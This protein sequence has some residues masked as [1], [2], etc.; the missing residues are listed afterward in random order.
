MCP[1]SKHSKEHPGAILPEAKRIITATNYPFAASI[2]RVT[3]SCCIQFWASTIGNT[4]V[5]AARSITKMVRRLEH[6]PGAD[7]LKDLSLSGLRTTR[8]QENTTAAAQYPG[9]RHEEGRAGFLT[10]CTGGGRDWRKGEIPS[11]VP[12]EAV[13]QWGCAISTPGGF[14]ALSNIVWHQSW[15]SSEQEAG[16]QSDLF[17]SLY[18]L[19][20]SE[21]L[22]PHSLNCSL[23]HLW[24]CLI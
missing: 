15:P 3:H 7:R 4:L 20:P 18:K 24:L 17:I 11:T 1:G 8:L 2:H 9:G 21:T 13:A 22:S 5:I 10:L 16:V 6:L 14:Q 19:A 12:V 23:S